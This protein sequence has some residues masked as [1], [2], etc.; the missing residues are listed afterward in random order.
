MYWQYVFI[1]KKSRDPIGKNNII[2]LT[3][4]SDFRH[5]LVSARSNQIDYPVFNIP[6]KKLY[7]PN[8]NGNTPYSFLIDEKCNTTD[9]F[10]IE[11][12]ETQKEALI[13]Y[14][15]FIADLI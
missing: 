12:L 2:V 13:S 3:Y 15:T 1:H 7:L 9:S 10:Y 4:Y 14:L 5:F 8:D 11:N 6:E